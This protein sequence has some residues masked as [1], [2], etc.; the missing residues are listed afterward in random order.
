MNKRNLILYF[1]LAGVLLVAFLRTKQG[2]EFGFEPMS[3]SFLVEIVINVIVSYSITATISAVVLALPITWIERNLPWTKNIWKRFFADLL[4]T[5]IF[6]VIAMYVIYHILVVTNFID[7]S[8]GNYM[9]TLQDHMEIAIVMD[10]L[11]VTVYEGIVLFRLWK[12]SIIRSERLEKENMVTR[13]EA[14]KN[15]INP[16]FLFNSLN[17][18]SSLIHEDVQKSEEFIDE[19]STIYRYILER[20][21]KMVSSVKEELDFARSFLHLLKIRF[22][23]ALITDIKVDQGKLNRYIP[24]LALQLLVENA[25]KHNKITKKEPLTIRIDIE[26]DYLVV[27]NNYQLRAEV[28]TSTKVGLKNLN[29]RYAILCDI[30]KPEFIVSG[31][32]YLAKIPLIEM[33]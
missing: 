28:T 5:P 16:H 6:A 30:L 33:E 27:A 32:E 7:H 24:T 2:I 13:F 15:Q 12:D 29:E 3:F 14:L 9:I 26:E 25:I 11:L 19:F 18:L 21:D 23:D 22:G 4:I 10:I 31:D 1:G 20:Q 8:H 17:T